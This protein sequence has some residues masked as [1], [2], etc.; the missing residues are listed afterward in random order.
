[1][2]LNLRG[3]VAEPMASVMVEGEPGAATITEALRT[4]EHLSKLASGDLAGT[5]ASPV[6]ARASAPSQSK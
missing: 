3:L 4:D 1:M 6:I 5:G 2:D